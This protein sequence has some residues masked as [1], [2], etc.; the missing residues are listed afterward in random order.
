MAGEGP[1]P[2]VVTKVA[3]IERCLTRVHDEYGDGVAFASD[4]T[5]Q[6]AAMLN[7]LRACETSIDLAMHLVRVLRLGVPRRSRDAFAELVRAGILDE[8]VGADLQ[9]MAG[10]RNL[11]VNR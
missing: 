8:R 1:D 11:A 4:V 10:F 9:R 6:D 3:Q 2:V 7:L 5:R